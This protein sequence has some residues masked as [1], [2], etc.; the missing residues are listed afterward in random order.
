VSKGVPGERHWRV[1]RILREQWHAGRVSNDTIGL[2]PNWRV[3][4]VYF[5]Y[6]AL[7]IRKN[8]ILQDSDLHIRSELSNSNSISISIQGKVESLDCDSSVRSDQIPSVCDRKAMARSILNSIVRE[9][10]PRP[11]SGR[12]PSREGETQMQS[13]RQI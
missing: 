10:V 7:P 5:D 1:V 2:H 9:M 11:R 13:Y 12:M 3:A 6:C 8:V 4:M